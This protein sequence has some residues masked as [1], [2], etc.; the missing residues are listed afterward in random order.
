MLLVCI[1]NYLRSVLRY[2]FL[3]LDTYYLYNIYMRQDVT[4]LG[5]FSK[6]KIAQA[7]GFWEHCCKTSN[8]YKNAVVQVS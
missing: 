2:T 7:E 8:V 5:C 6:P 3:I 4:T 1:P